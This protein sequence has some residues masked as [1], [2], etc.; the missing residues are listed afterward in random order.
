MPGRALPLAPATE[1][2]CCGS[3]ASDEAMTTADA[4]ATAY[5][6]KA[7]ADPARLRL[8]SLIRSSKDQEACVCDLTPAV[9]LSQPTVSH[10]LKVLTEAGL[11]T[12]ERR[13]TWAWFRLVP[14][15]LD[16]LAAIFR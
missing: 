12:R 1:E 2:A 5:L 11:L 10:H 9:G 8:L 7:V 16:D 6:L 4:E 14:E 3:L 13:G 15:R